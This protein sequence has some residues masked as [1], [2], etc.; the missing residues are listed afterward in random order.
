MLAKDLIRTIPNF[1]KSGVLFRDITPVLSNL[2]AFEEVVDRLARIPFIQSADIIAGVEARGFIVGAALAARGRYGFIP[3]RKGGKLPGAKVQLQST[4]EYDSPL[5]EIHTDAI[6]PGQ[7]VAIIDDVLATGG[8]AMTAAR[9]IENLGGVVSGFGFMI[10][11]SEL[12]G[13]KLI[14]KHGY[15]QEALI[16]TMAVEDHGE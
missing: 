6:N 13:R 16:Y 14:A 7:K 1:P 10:E 8:T 5:L 3:I 4:S 9:L 15:K 11:I 2:I 12:G